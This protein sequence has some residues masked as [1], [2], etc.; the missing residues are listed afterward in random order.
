[1]K[2][3]LTHS[4]RERTKVHLAV[5]RVQVEKSLR[6]SE[7]RFNQVAETAREF[8]WEVD[9]D[10]TITYVSPAF[11]TI[12]GYAPEEVIGSRRFFDFFAPEE[13]E[14]QRRRIAEIML[15]EERL[16]GLVTK[17]NRRDGSTLYCVTNALPYRDDHG[18]LLGYRGVNA[19]ITEQK[20]SEDEI[21]Q[22]HRL[23]D[24][25]ISY[26]RSAIAVH[27]R[28]MR[29]IYVSREYLRQ[30]RVR[31]ENVIGRH[32]YDVFPDLPEKWREAHRLALTGQV[33]SGEDDPYTRED[34]S[35]D[36]TRWECRPWYELDGS[37]GGIIVY[38]EVL[39]TK[40]E[41]VERNRCQKPSS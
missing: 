13:S 19:D 41:G 27:D 8:I 17:N 23:L 35:V 10:G 28:E 12:V 22:S 24:Y 6:E 9:R 15:M 21:A 16:T 7:K 31:E 33:C 36:W 20:R 26:A 32:H 37:I 3:C 39:S 2:C 40:R 34:G 38:T 30:Y 5:Q 11:Q 4:I 14:Q 29:Y 18:R 1:M 25:V